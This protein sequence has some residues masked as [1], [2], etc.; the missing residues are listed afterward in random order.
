MNHLV[1]QLNYRVAVAWSRM[2]EYLEMLYAFGVH[3]ADHACLDKSTSIEIDHDSVDVKVGM[4][5][6]FSIGMIQK[7]GDFMM[8]KKSP[9]LGE[10]EVRIEM[11]TNYTPAKFDEIMKLFNYLMS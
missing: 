1:S 6:Y 11:G 7:I 3:S 8:G 9:F 5:Y 10:G 4:H 2:H